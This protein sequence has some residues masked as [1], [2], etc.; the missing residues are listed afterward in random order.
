[1]LLAV[2]DGVTDNLTFPELRRLLHGVANDP[3]D[4]AHRI[5]DAAYTRSRQT[6]HPEPRSTTSPPSL[7]GFD[8]H[9]DLLLRHDLDESRSDHSTVAR[10][11][12]RP[13][14]G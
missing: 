3:V 2:S 6:G 5:V 10:P 8:T 11:G 12:R 14:Q 4:T 13:P 9:A 7:P 1:M